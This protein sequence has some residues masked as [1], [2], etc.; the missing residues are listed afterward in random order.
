MPSGSGFKVCLR[1]FWTYFSI[2]RTTAFGEG[3]FL[4]F[5]RCGN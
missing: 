3:V 4:S 1:D 5:C 2:L